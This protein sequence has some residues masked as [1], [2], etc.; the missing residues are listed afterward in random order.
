MRILLVSYYFPPSGRAHAYRWSPIVGEWLA[1]GHSVDVVAGIETSGVGGEEGCQA[2]RGLRLVRTGS[3]MINRLRGVAPTTRGSAAA[4]LPG[5]SLL[6]SAAK[7][8]LR[9]AYRASFWP[10]GLWHWYP[11]ALSAARKLATQPYDLLVTYSPTFVAHL[12]GLRL[13]RAACATAWLADY[14][15]PFSL[16]PKMPANNSRLYGR[17]N[18]HFE[19]K[20]IETATATSFTNAATRDLYSEQFGGGRKLLVIPN[21]VALPAS[22][23]ARTR[24]RRHG[25]ARLTYV[26]ALHRQ[27][28]E[29][30]PVIANLKAA[31]EARPGSFD[32]RFVGRLNGVETIAHPAIAWLGEVDKAAAFRYMQDADVLIHIENKGVP[33]TPSKVVD[34]IAAA[35]P[36]LNFYSDDVTPLLA[37][38]PY[39]LDLRLE[40][41]NTAAILSFIDH[42]RTIE[43]S[44]DEVADHL[45][46]H[47]AGSIASDVL[48]LVGRGNAQARSPG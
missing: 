18:R 41:D 9:S 20:V 5:T 28:R 3:P 17:L 7:N 32:I 35:R 4:P 1:R 25:P 29:P 15:D 34:Y 44:G 12:V 8:A 37:D 6:A 42:A 14:G 23:E 19:R 27:I 40:D 46:R 21:A 26:G 31:L 10:D 13:F 47:D 16:S 30:A 36:I 43:I 2:S 45:R 22:A 24:P 38:W 33:M 11:Y 39:A 48:D